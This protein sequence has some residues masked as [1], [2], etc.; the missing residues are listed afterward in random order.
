MRKR[1]RIDPWPATR[2]WQPPARFPDPD[3]PESDRPDTSRVA[4]ALGVVSLLFA[5]LGVVAWAFASS[6]L[7]AIADGKMDPAG[8]TNA[9][10]GRV[11]GIIATCI[12]LLKFAVLVP[13]YVYTHG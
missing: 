12:F 5:P 1:T 9:R 10:A 7:K 4:L 2:Y 6:C 13:L 11:L 8:E 3:P